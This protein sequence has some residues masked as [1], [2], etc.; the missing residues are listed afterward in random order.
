MRRPELLVLAGVHG[1]GK[2]SVV[3]SRLLKAGG[4][5]FNPD[6]YAHTL[7]PA[8]PGAASDDISRRAWEYGRGLLAR[9]IERRRDFAIETT[10]GGRT[11][12]AL[13]MAAARTHD[14][15]VLFMGLD[16][17]ERHLRRVA[18]RVRAGGH[19][20]PESLLR[21]RFTSSR[22]HLIEL[23]PVLAGLTLYD[24]SIESAVHSGERARPRRLLAVRGRS[25]A[26]EVTRDAMPNWAK[27]IVQAARD[28]A[29]APR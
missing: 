7:L 6:E 17:V 28:A 10:L 27:P 2:S 13:L 21:A 12:P 15:H 18:D 5:F 29:R 20:I 23:V 16:S 26:F 1:A 19:D 25:I 24:N 9:A 3:G 4:R 8:A 22:L 11:I 14:V